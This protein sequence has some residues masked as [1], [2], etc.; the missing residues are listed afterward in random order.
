MEQ[1]VDIMALSYIISQGGI[2]ND[3]L[4]VNN[5]MNN[6]EGHTLPPTTVQMLS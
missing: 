3:N 5:L 2:Q 6:F 1:T 4:G